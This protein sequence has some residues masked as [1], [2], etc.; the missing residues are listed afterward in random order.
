MYNNYHSLK[1]SIDKSISSQHSVLNKFPESIARPITQSCAKHLAQFTS[2]QL[3][4]SLSTYTSSSN[5][6]SSTS[7]PSNKVTTSELTSNNLARETSSAPYSQSSIT[8]ASIVSSANANTS[9]SSSDKTEKPNIIEL[10]TIEQVNWALEVLKIS[11]NFKKS[12]N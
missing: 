11:L 4:L 6:N 8:T 12:L 1:A 7:T 5:T 3:P 2:H 10:D 9:Q